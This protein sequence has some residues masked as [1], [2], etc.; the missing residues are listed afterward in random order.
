MRHIAHVG[1]KFTNGQGFLEIMIPN[2]LTPDYRDYRYVPSQ[3][4]HVVLGMR[5]RD[6]YMIG[7]HFAN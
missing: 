4:V 3:P 7:K 1:F 6:W 2:T 5:T